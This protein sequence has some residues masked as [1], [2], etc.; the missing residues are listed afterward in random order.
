MYADDTKIFQVIKAPADRIS[1][2]K[3]LDMAYNWSEKWLKFHL[4][5]C[6]AMHIRAKDREEN[7]CM[8]TMAG[9]NVLDTIEYEKDIGVIIDNKLEFDRHIQNIVNKANQVFGIIGRSF[10]DMSIGPFLLYKSMVRSYMDYAVSVWNPYK[11]KY[12]EA[13][14]NVQRR[15]TRQLAAHQTISSTERPVL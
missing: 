12:I 4:N 1:L 14:E 8:Y 13:L 15:A 9:V 7:Y 6:K 10:S 3:D 11:V 2:Q 5:K